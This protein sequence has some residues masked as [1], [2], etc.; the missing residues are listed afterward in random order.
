MRSP[1]QKVS[2]FNG[3]WLYNGRARIRRQSFRATVVSMLLVVSVSKTLRKT[4]IRKIT[5]TPHEQRRWGER[6]WREVL[7]MEQSNGASP[8]V[9][10]NV[11][12]T[13]WSKTCQVLKKHLFHRRSSHVVCSAESIIHLRGSAPTD[14]QPTCFNPLFTIGLNFIKQ[15]FMVYLLSVELS[16]KV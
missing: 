14:T 2:G 11:S 1:T 13:C 8:H 4:S 10:H 15:D 9:M 5:N 6:R 7:A 12:W 3:G 16:T